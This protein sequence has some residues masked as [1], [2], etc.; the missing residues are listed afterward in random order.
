[1]TKITITTSSFGK[2]NTKP[3]EFLKKEGLE[4]SLNPY[5]RKLTA[6]D[7]VE[8]CSNATGIIAGTETL[9]RDVIE[10]LKDLK[11]ISRCGVGLDSVDLNAA[12]E[13]NIKVFNTPDGPTIAVAELTVGLMINLLRKTVPMNSSLKKDDKW[14]KLMGNLVFG[15]KVGI[16]GFGRIGK[17]V[18]GLL[19][20][21][22]CE[23]K[24]ADPFIKADIPGFEQLPLEKLLSWSDMV[25][26]HVSAGKEII[27]EKEINLMKKGSWLINI[28]RGG[29]VDEDALHEALGSGYLSGAALDVFA[30]EPYKGPLKKLDNVILTPHIGSYAM[31]SR[32]QMEMQ[33]AENLIKGLKQ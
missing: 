11:V 24:Y 15:K 23:I 18:A 17:K 20:A 2:Y 3:M 30:E 28:S 8:L 13:L 21:F 19:S 29:V 9:D 26:I 4:I 1:M 32:V 6:D 10:Q 14:K 27:G 33:A 25:S 7:V 5:G 22:G 16:V 31:E 12:K